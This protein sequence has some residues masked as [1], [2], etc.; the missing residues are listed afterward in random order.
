MT[1]WLARALAW[2]VPPPRPSTAPGAKG[3]GRALVIRTDDRVGNVLLT[4]PLVRALREAGWTVDLLV[5]AGKAALAEGS[6][7]ALVRFEKRD[8][9]RRPWRLVAL[10]RALRRARYDVAIDAAHWHAFSLTSALLAR[11]TGAARIVG[12]RRGPWSRFYTHAVAPAGNAR[13]TAQKLR[14]LEPLNVK[15]S[16]ESLATALGADGRDR[17]AAL[18][19]LATAGVGRRFALVNPG[20]RKAD[21]RWPASSFAALARGL[22]E[23]G[24]D[25][26]VTWGPGE[27]ALAAAV[28]SSSESALA[29]ATALPTLAALLRLAALAVTNDTGPMHLAV[30]CGAPTVALFAGSDAARWGHAGTFAAVDAAAPDALEQALAAAAE[31]TSRARP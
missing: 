14:L 13:E 30:A 19:V 1:P 5:A 26:L 24:L 18:A 3:G 9:F 21:H 6:A 15:H 31:L 23:R 27:R 10:L 22:K 20:A 7:D 17:D 12:H 25:V 8:A 4:L 28:A 16:N 11:W 29:P 2:L